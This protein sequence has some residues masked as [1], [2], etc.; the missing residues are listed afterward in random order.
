[1]NT[2]SLTEAAKAV[3]AAGVSLVVLESTGG[4]ERPVCQ[5]LWRA[6]VPVAVVNPKRIRDYAR[7]CG[8]MA[9]TDR[10]DAAVIARYA[11]SLKP[12]AQNQTNQELRDLSGRRRTLVAQRTAEKNRLD[13]TL[14]SQVRIS[15][16][17][18]I[19]WLEREIAR[20]ESAITEVVRASPELSARR[21]AL[22]S[23][24][25]V[26]DVTAL[27]LLA[28]MPE[29]GSLSRG[30]AAA[31]A[32]VAPY[33]CDSGQMRG[34]RRIYGG[35]STVRKTLY[36][37]TLVAVQFNPVLKQHYQQLRDRG[38]CAKVALVA[39]MRKLIIYLNSIVRSNEL[40]RAHC[41]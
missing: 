12:T 9:K 4:Y 33:N 22:I 35:R 14:A 2:A 30:A 19:G 17:R 37:A 10:L 11:A 36:M 5:A 16:K 6:E 26:G 1:M 7:A 15:I 40:V 31:L 18:S 39:C 41:P 29:L 27:H 8:I 3:C 24:K 25:G 34:Q 32:G 38:K 28:E 20:I 21:D 13:H 23:V